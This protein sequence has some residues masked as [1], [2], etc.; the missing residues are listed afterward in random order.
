[1]GFYG[2]SS[3]PTLC[4]WK[5]KEIGSTIPAEPLP[6]CARDPRQLLGA[7]HQQLS[8]HLL[9]PPALSAIQSHGQHGAIFCYMRH[10][11]PGRHPRIVWSD[12]LE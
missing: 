4:T 8:P 1:M 5:Q 9:Q 10:R 7:Q 12:L 3:Q 11:K 2:S 6:L